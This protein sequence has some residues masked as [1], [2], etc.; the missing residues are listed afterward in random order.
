[1]AHTGICTLVVVYTLS[2]CACSTGEGPAQTTA[3]ATLSARSSP[4]KEVPP[5]GTK[6]TAPEPPPPPSSLTARPDAGRADLAIVVKPSDSEAA[7]HYTLTC[8]EGAP[9]G[10]TNHPFA[11]KACQVV[12][13]NPGVL[14]PQPRNKEVV[15]TQQYGGPQTATVTG[16]VDGVPVDVSFARRDGCEISQWNAAASILGFTGDL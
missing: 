15:C 1:M 3:S 5:T 11:T 10:E 8:K 13:D 9:T 12:R 16:T 6:T 7:I 14:M 2:L 4:T